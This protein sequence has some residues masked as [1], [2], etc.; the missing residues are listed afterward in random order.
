M[1][2][3][4]ERKDEKAK[5]NNKKKQT[6]VADGE[7]GEKKG[8]ERKAE[9]WEVTDMLNDRKSDLISYSDALAAEIWKRKI[10]CT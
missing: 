9:E 6:Q 5:Q 3:E 10:I 4:W 8:R 1:A 2:E 7:K